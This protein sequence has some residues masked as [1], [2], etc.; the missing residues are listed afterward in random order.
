MVRERLAS[1]VNK[2]SIEAGKRLEPANDWTSRVDIMNSVHFENTR[3][4]AARRKRIAFGAAVGPMMLVALMACEPPTNLVHVA[5]TYAPDSVRF[6]VSGIDG[7]VPPQ[8]PVYGL[9]VV[10]CDTQDA[11]WTIAAGGGRLLPDTVRYGRPIPG[12]QVTAGP[13]PLT[14]GCYEVLVTEAKAARFTVASP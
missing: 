2:Q 6:S 5:P 13:R 7:T 3:A 1:C 14:P 4:A 11:Y 9:S 12:F 8:Q 10:R